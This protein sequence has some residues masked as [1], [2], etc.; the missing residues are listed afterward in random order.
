MARDC[1]SATPNR[2]LQLIA[3]LSGARLSSQL[4]LY[5]VCIRPSW[6]YMRSKGT[7][8]SRYWTLN[9]YLKLPFSKE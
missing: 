2:P 6:S 1:V 4:C 9:R 3:R 5:R 8:S 7:K